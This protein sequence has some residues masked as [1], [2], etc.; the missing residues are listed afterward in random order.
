MCRVAIAS[1]LVAVVARAEVQRSSAQFVS[2]LESFI[3]ALRKDPSAPPGFAIVVVQGDRTLFERAYGTRDLRSKDPLTVNAPIYTAS[4]TKS[5]VGLL[6]AQLDAA[7]ILPLDATMVDVWPKLVLPAPL[8]ASHVTARSLLSHV[9]GVEAP[10]LGWRYSDTGEYR[11]EDVPEL[12]ARY[13]VPANRSFDYG[14]I[15]PVLYTAMVETRLERSW[16]DALQQYVARP[17][18]LT[19]TSARLEDFA[20]SEIGQCH[21]RSG[22]QW[23]VVAQKPTVLLDAGGGVLASAH[24]AGNYLRAFTSDGKSAGGAIPAAVLKKTYQKAATQDRQFLGF[25]RTGY[26]LGWDLSEYAGHEVVSR[27]GGYPG[28]RSMMAFLPKE[29]F[30]VV[31]FALSDQ[32]GNQFNVSI[33]QQ[34]FDY[35][36]G[37]AAAA[38]RASE[39]VSA[40]ATAAGEAIANADK[41]PVV[42]EDRSAGA[43][44]EYVGWYDSPGLGRVAVSMHPNGMEVTS[45]ALRLLLAPESKDHFAA[46]EASIPAA[47][48]PLKF[49]RDAGGAVD[50]FIFRDATFVKRSS[51]N[52]K[53]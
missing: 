29:R 27:S 37:D 50:A 6:A 38:A 26:G 32:G 23:V 19:R 53:D 25:H 35:W 44:A 36:T 51:S 39:R 10:V 28:C 30:G 17:L 41:V 5:F 42:S 1:A 4:T 18:K 7:G 11:S 3:D 16:R 48:R 52:A 40:F 46:Y 33:V 8:D 13:A 22:R 47:P 21:T 43:A 24:D 15:G 31:V 45:G 20:P 9:S 34:A 2:R 14:N 49:H 12:L